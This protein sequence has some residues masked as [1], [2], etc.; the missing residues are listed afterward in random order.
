MRK[1]AEELAA[2]RGADERTLRRLPADA[3]VP[4]SALPDLADDLAL[5]RRAEEAQALIDS[6]IKPEDAVKLIRAKYFPGVDDPTPKIKDDPDS[7]PH[8]PRAAPRSSA[9]RRRGRVRA[10]AG[11]IA[12]RRRPGAAAQAAAE[13]EAAP[14]E[15]VDEAAPPAEGADD[16]A[17]RDPS[18]ELTP[19]ETR[20]HRA[21]ERA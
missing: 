20:V 12:P 21:G 2:K 10:H 4:L 7:F 6:G 17:V 13:G 3:D 1:A 9:N 18:T 11:E 16:A 19:E 5:T 8:G 14:A 15:G